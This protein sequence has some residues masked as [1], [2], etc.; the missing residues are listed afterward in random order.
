MAVTLP[1]L[2]ILINEVK[3]G[4]E[5]PSKGKLFVHGLIRKLHIFSCREQW[6]QRKLS[7]TFTLFSWYKLKIKKEGDRLPVKYLLAL[8]ASDLYH[9]M[10][11]SEQS[12]LTSSMKIFYY[13]GK[14]VK[15]RVALNYLLLMCCSYV[16]NSLTSG[17][18]IGSFSCP[19]CI[20]SVLNVY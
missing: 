2:E 20:P 8:H 10:P 12:F 11:T 9:I 1:V 4:R 7:L 6:V 14:A 5:L 15:L 18:A 17:L 13:S 3:S 16:S 19:V